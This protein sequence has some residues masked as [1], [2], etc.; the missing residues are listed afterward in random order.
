MKCYVAGSLHK[1]PFIAQWKIL[2][3]FRLHK[4]GYE[5]VYVVVQP[6]VKMDLTCSTSCMLAFAAG[7]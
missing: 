3:N 4:N 7:T 5:L 1:L 6:C 2:L